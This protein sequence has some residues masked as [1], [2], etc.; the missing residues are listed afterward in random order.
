MIYE[1]TERK[2]YLIPLLV[3]TILLSILYSKAW[4]GSYGYRYPIISNGTILDMPYSINDTNLLN[5]T[6]YWTRNTSETIYVYCVNS[7]CKTGNISIA[8]DT[9]EK[10]WEREDTLE[11]N[12]PTSVW[13]VNYSAVWHM[14]NKT[15]L[16]ATGKTK[17]VYT[18]NGANVTT[19]LF[20][21][22]L[23]F[24]RDS[25]SGMYNFTNPFS[26]TD[27]TFTIEMWIKS[28][29]LT[30]AN[31]Y[32]ILSWRK[33]N[34]DRAFSYQGSTNQIRFRIQDESGTANDV[35]LTWNENF[36]NTW[37]YLVG[38]SNSTGIFLYHNGTFIN[39]EISVGTVTW[40][41]QNGVMISS[42]AFPD[43]ND[44]N[45]PFNGTIEEIRWSNTNRSEAYIKEQYEM[46]MN[47][48]SGLSTEE[49]EDSTP[50][51]Y[52]LNSTNSTT[53][54]ES[55]EHRLK[56]EDD[57]GLA[58]TGGYIF[59]FDNCTGTLA[60]DTWIVFTK[61]PDWSNVTKTINSTLGCII[62]WCVY[63]ND[64]SN[65]W[66]GSSCQ[67]PFSYNT[68]LIDSTTTSSS[69]T[70]TTNGD[71]TTSTT[72]TTT[73]S[74]TTTIPISCVSYITTFNDSTI[75]KN[76]TFTE[77][78]N[79]TAWISISKY[80]YV[81]D[82]KLNVSGYDTEIAYDDW[83]F[84]I[85]GEE[86]NPSGLTSNG[87]HFWIIGGNN[88]VFRYN[89]TGD[90]DDWNFDVSEKETDSRG[91]YF[92]GSHYWIVGMDAKKVFRYNSTGDY[93]NWNFSVSGQAYS[94][95]DIYFN[96]SHFWI[97]N[98]LTKKVFR[99]NSTGDYDDWNF[100]V[101]RGNSPR[102]IIFNGTY[103]WIA[104]LYGMIYR[105]NST[106]DYDDWNFSL[107]YT[108][109]TS[110]AFNE[111]YFW[112]V[113]G[114]KDKVYRYKRRG[115]PKNVSL[116]VTND[117][118]IE[119]S[120]TREF[121]HSKNRTSDFSQEINDI[122]P[123]CNCNGCSLSGNNCTFPLVLHSD[124]AGIIQMDDLNITTSLGL[125][126]KAYDE[127]SLEQIYFDVLIFNDT[128]N[129]VANNSWEL[130]TTCEEIPTGNITII[131]KNDSYVDRYYYAFFN[132]SMDLSA[133]LLQTTDGI[134]ITFLVVDDYNEVQP[135]TL[136]SARRYL[137]ATWKTVAQL[138][139][140]AQGKGWF[141]L[142]AWT[143]YK[144][145]AEKSFVE[146]L[147][148][149]YYPNS[150]YVLTIVLSEEAIPYDMTYV[151]DD[152]SY[153]IEPNTTYVDNT[154]RFKFFISSSS[155]SLEYYG[156]NVTWITDRNSTFLF[157]QTDST[158]SGGEI[159]VD[160]NITSMTVNMTTKGKIDVVAFFKKSGYSLYEIKKRY[161]IW[162]EQSIFPP[163]FSS[164][165][166]GTF[167][168]SMFATNIIS[169]IASGGLA[170]GISKRWSTIT[171]VIPFLGILA[172]FVVGG[173]FGWYWYL[174]MALLGFG[175]IILQRVY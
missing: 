116:D 110:I 118:D 152:I 48:L 98:D 101:T 154:T 153:F 19:G 142:S 121:N 79:K 165:A 47:R 30:T 85:S 91:I 174:A 109:I 46:G 49:T 38:V 9:H 18:D 119:W 141:F 67:N 80:S 45:N 149:S 104:D 3:L 15:F 100:S 87:T 14:H 34:R 99:Y 24:S 26:G 7:G 114:S 134:Y 23:N 160:I 97:I 169:L 143:N 144:I 147:I 1:K 74:S 155:S 138:K 4:W 54:G 82:A 115:F 77:A 56:W 117:G 33:V 16:D 58:T 132:E 113:S 20:G 71:G 95:M 66:N 52:S 122:L 123:S 2:I 129:Y 106:G 62:H 75:A 164:L 53:A 135:D 32:Y 90:Y 60:N 61:N 21:Q 96:G 73:S 25:D 42:N 108:S 44:A 146:A 12:N 92:N 78:G 65:N 127:N 11:G 94:P 112:V 86:I 175:I 64:T 105:Y 63:A 36:E 17:V 159:W 93:D 130:Q 39:K 168:L 102:G 139:S 128:T 29:E 84:D 8:N 5:G 51:T 171:P 81:T 172:I 89:S 140:D 158:P 167:G 133:Y 22:A 157:N 120:Y 124:T 31:N 170:M 161:I 35:H 43:A 166:V 145:L 37:Q 68:T 72:T 126:L 162:F 103:F 137:N 131:V 107:S 88:K 83:N 6:V 151:L 28:N 148:D 55:I 136:V 125:N 50:P 27:N 163:I 57:V 156:L 173:W 41:D 111:T 10:Y 40:S 59:S 69:T 76:L 70:T 13:D 150:N